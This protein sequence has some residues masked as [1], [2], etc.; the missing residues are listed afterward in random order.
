MMRRLFIF[1]IIFMLSLFQFGI[2]P[3]VQADEIDQGPVPSWVKKRD[4]DIL[5]I[6]IDQNSKAKYQH[7]LED[8]QIYFDR[9]G[10]QTYHRTVKY[11][12]DKSP[13]KFDGAV[14][15]F[16]EATYQTHRIHHLKIWRDNKE[17]DALK[18]AEI[19]IQNASW[20]IFKGSENPRTIG[21]MP[22]YL[23]EGDI[24][25]FAYSITGQNDG[26]KN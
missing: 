21:L 25:D 15:L 23:K 18:F 10:R 5:K 7:L 9:K 11:I 26:L 14:T 17:I 12:S 22:R 2:S 20:M 13:Y 16:Y 3:S 1:K 19:T 6:P 24:V 8:K 4:I